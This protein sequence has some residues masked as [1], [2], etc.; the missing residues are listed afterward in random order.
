MKETELFKKG[1]TTPYKREVVKTA[2]ELRDDT[3]KGLTHSIIWASGI[4]LLTLI[5]CITIKVKICGC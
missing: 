5:I 3:G 2:E 1:E 4:V